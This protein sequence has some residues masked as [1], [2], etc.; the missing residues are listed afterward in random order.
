MIAVSVTM[1]PAAVMI[2][3]AAPI[4]IMGRVVGHAVRQG[5]VELARAGGGWRKRSPPAALVWHAMGDKLR[6]ASPLPRCPAAESSRRMDRG[7]ARTESAG[8]TGTSTEP[9]GSTANPWSRTPT[10]RGW[11]RHA[12]EAG[13]R[14]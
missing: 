13:V 4:S 2:A 9:G 8:G 3:A 5:A 10:K 1:V 11:V 12:A 7:R 14:P 6:R